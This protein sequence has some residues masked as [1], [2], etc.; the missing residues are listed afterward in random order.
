MFAFK[1]IKFPGLVAILLV[2]LFEGQAAHLPARVHH[3][4]QNT[5]IHSEVHRHFETPLTP[6]IHTPVIVQDQKTSD[7]SVSPSRAS[8]DETYLETIRHFETPLTPHIHTPVIVQDQKTSDNAASSTR[9]SREETHMEAVLHLE[10]P[11][12]PH[13]HTPVIVQDQK[14][15]DKSVFP[16]R[17]SRDEGNEKPVIS[18]IP[19]VPQCLEG[20]SSCENVGNAVSLSPNHF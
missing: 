2:L 13:V 5:Q 1:N 20:W 9:T 15:S 3:L 16:T 10:T 8:R 7:T 18:S 4:D 6:H 19:S 14:T 12:T 11:L 17:V